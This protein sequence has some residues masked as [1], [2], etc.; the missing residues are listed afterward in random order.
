MV[1]APDKVN[2]KKIPNEDSQ[3]FELNDANLFNPNRLP[4]LDRVEGGQRINYGVG[5]GWYGANGMHASGFL[6][7]SLYAGRPNDLPQGS[8]LDDTFSDI[9]GRLLLAPYDWFDLM[10]RFRL[11]HDDLA[12]QRQEVALRVGQPW[13]ELTTQYVSLGS[14]TE[15]TSIFDTREQIR[16]LLSS[17]LSEH[18]TIFGGT[19]YDLASDDPLRH[20]LGFRYSDECFTFLGMYTKDFTSDRELQKDERIVFRV[21]LKNL[22]E[23]GFGQSIGE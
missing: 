16:V 11:K 18:W 14:D 12:F 19:R 2:P 23:V 1:I 4:G 21:I 20:Q 8:G 3:I 13:L 17:Q 9:V 22:G 15:N 10:Y 5:V 6:G 7:Q